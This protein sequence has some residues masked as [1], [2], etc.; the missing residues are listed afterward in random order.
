MKFN[1][2]SWLKSG[3]IAATV[4][5]FASCKKDGD[6]DEVQAF[7]QNVLV[8]NQ[9]G[10]QQNNASVSYY[11]HETGAV[12]KDM[13]G[14]V[15]ANAGLGDLAQD[16]K[17]F[18]SKI[19]ITVNG[20]NKVE[21]LDSQTFKKTS[22]VTI[23]SPRWLASANGKVFVSSYDDNVY[24]LDGNTDQIVKK[25]EVGRDPEHMA[26]VGNKLYVANSGGLD[27]PLYENTVSVIDLTSLT[28]SKK[29]TVDINPNL[30]LADKYGDVYVVTVGDYGTIK[31]NIYV[32]NSNTDEARAL[33]LRATGM[34]IN[35]DV[36]YIY[37]AEYSMVAGG[38]EISYSTLNVKN[39]I[40]GP[41]FIRDGSET[42]IK[43]PYGIGV[44]SGS[45]DIYL[46]DAKD[47]QA[48]GTV[49]RFDKDGK[50]KSFFSV[51]TNP[52]AFCFLDK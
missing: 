44:D 38:Y 47:F 21:I 32:I 41:S 26:V 24:V 48:E 12:T 3:I 22:S 9:G 14:A 39:E 16:I 31:S 35:N 46:A 20:S 49:F 17:V 50:Q 29:I 8:L 5:T 36:A 52:S 45:G 34:V 1:R 33:N 6:S 28:E 23:S 40:P 25:I 18:G 11:N 13:Y 10:F 4:L 30:V 42:A 43:L 2:F 51:G 27:Y 37:K 15:N 7:N 19:Y